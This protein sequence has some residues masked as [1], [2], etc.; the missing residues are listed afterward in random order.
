MHGESISESVAGQ[1][2]LGAKQKRGRRAVD[3]MREQGKDDPI[4][5][6]EP[7]GYLGARGACIKSSTCAIMSL[8]VHVPIL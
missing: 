5:P 7:Q 4:T 8:Y 2:Y 1:S 6:R 3:C